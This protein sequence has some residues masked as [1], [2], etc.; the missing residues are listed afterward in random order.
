MMTYMASKPKIL[1][2]TGGGG[3]WGL[4]PQTAEQSWQLHGP[5]TSSTDSLQPLV[6]FLMGSIP[7]TERSTRR[8]HAES[9]PHENPFQVLH[10]LTFKP[11]GEHTG[12]SGVQLNTKDRALLGKHALG[13]GAVS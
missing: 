5:V 3:G 9:G 10:L 12:Y 6:A 1:Q 8:N 13:F 11:H 2:G 7:R 4:G